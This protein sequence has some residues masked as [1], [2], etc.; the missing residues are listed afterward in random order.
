LCELFLESP[1]VVLEVLVPLELPF[2]ILDI[3]L[4]FNLPVV[5]LLELLSKL[6]KFDTKVAA[7]FFEVLNLGLELEDFI[8]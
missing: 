6:V 8:L 5:L 4:E 1:N 3:S 2:Y 7:F